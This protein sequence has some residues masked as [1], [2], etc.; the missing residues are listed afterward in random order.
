MVC[1]KYVPDKLLDM[2]INKN[3]F[4]YGITTLVKTRKTV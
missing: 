1:Q 2:D 3:V 4:V